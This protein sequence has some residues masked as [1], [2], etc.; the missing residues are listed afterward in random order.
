MF[1]Q[2]LLMRR[3]LF[4]NFLTICEWSS[5]HNT[6]LGCEEAG[7]QDA[8]PFDRFDISPCAFGF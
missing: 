5:L 7:H 8:M 6:S 4:N 2:R 3:R 1:G